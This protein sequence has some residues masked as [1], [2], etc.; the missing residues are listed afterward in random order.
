VQYPMYGVLLIVT[1]L[2]LPGGVAGAA[3]V[4]RNRLTRSGGHASGAPRSAL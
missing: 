3:A 4:V 2:V 1:V